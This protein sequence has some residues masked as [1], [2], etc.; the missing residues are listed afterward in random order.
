MEVQEERQNSLLR[1]H[2]IRFA[3]GCIQLSV[4]ALERMII[5]ET[6]SR[7]ARDLIVVPLPL[8]SV[9]GLHKPL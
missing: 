2:P 5:V 7:F 3:S 1:C 6:A 4:R 9:Q 8:D